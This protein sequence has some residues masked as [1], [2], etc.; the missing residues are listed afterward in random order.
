MTLTISAG[1]LAPLTERGGVGAVVERWHWAGKKEL[2]SCLAQGTEAKMAQI[3]LASPLLARETQPHV[4]KRENSGTTSTGGKHLR[5]CE[6]KSP[7]V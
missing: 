6:W 5:G 1:E 3:L 4:L 7:F 2:S